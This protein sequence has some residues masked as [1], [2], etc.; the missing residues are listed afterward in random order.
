[1][2]AVLVICVGALVAALGYFVFALSSLQEMLRERQDAENGLLE[3]ERRLQAVIDN[4]TAMIAVTDLEGRFILVNDAFERA[5]SRGRIDAVGRTAGE[6]MSAEV[7]DALAMHHDDAL[8]S[9]RPVEF[10]LEMSTLEGERCYM[11]TKFALRNS[12]GKPYAVCGAYTDVTA[13]KRLEEE[14][15]RIFDLSLDMMC[16]TGFDGYQKVTN[17]RFCAELGWSLD[18]FA[19]REFMEF[20]HPDDHEA[21]MAAVE[22]LAG[23]DSLVDFENRGL[24]KDGSYKWL[25][26]RIAPDIEEGLM[27]CVGRPI[28]GPS[29]TA[30]SKPA[31]AEGKRSESPERAGR[32][33]SLRP[34][35]P[36]RSRDSH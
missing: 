14:R 33:V 29:R 19:S 35:R 36:G 30:E 17:P 6:L 32:I 24:C 12:A 11:V 27:I 28:A 21:T 2:L 9:P 22:R 31:T 34:G 3:S 13:R 18:D 5:L 25:S 1:M 15:S 4:T 20:V 26:W 16:V 8:E 7:T 10:D 23:G